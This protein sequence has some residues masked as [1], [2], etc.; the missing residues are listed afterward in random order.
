MALSVQYWL[1]YVAEFPKL[2]RKSED[3]VN[4][5]HVLKFVYDVEQQYI[6]AVVQS[7][8][9]DKSYSVRVCIVKWIILTLINCVIIIIRLLAFLF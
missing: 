8:F 1:H 7:S 6:T 4:S 2:A 9:R 5:N 3:A